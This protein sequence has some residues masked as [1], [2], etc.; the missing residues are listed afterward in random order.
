LREV[1][2]LARTLTTYPEIDR[3]HSAEE[4]NDVREILLDLISVATETGGPDT[5]VRMIQ[6]QAKTAVE[7]MPAED[8]SKFVIEPVTVVTGPGIKPVVLAQNPE[9]TS[10]LDIAQGLAEG[11]AS[12]GVFQNGGWRVIRRGVVVYQANRIVY[13][14]LAIKTVADR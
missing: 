1:S 6:L 11:I 10:A 8:L 7:T 3:L 4:L 13:D 2:I 14:C 12:N 9:L 5:R